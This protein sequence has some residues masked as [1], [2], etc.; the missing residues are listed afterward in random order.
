MEHKTLDKIRDVADILPSW[1]SPR[2]LSKSERLECWAEAL[3]REGG[4]HLKTLFEIEHAPPLKRAALRADDSLLTVAF[5]DPRLRA[6]GLAGDTVGDAVAF[7]GVS[8]KELHDILCFC[9][10]GA[11]MAA[12]AAAAQVRAAAARRQVDALQMVVGTFVAVSM[13]VGLLV[14]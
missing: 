11:T 13:A 6:E 10:H 9:H 3:E 2:P 8:E 1:L 12:D 7:F 14:A 5:N 4:R